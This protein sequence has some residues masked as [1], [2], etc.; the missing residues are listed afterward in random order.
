[1]APFSSLSLPTREELQG[2]DLDGWNY[3]QAHGY[4]NGVAIAVDGGESAGFR[5]LKPGVAVH[6]DTPAR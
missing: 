3:R 6:G 4:V 5:R 1:M 2:R